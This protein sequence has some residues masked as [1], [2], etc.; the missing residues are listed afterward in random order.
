MDFNRIIK[1]VVVL[2]LVLF[3]WKAGLPWLKKQNFGGSTASSSATGRSGAESSCIRSAENASGAWGNGIG[4]FVNPPY[5]T[6]AWA[7]FRSDVESK[8]GNAESACSCTQESCEKVRTSMRELRGLISEI[9]GAI[10]GNGSFPEDAVA[11]QERIDTLI[12]E[13]GDLV[14]AGK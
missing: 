8:I 1:A 11:R 5:D 2:G 4:R 10:R 3:V 14:R 9:D 13:A 7:S 6:S 12:N